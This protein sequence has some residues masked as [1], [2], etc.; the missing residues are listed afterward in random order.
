[1]KQKISETDLIN[2]WMQKIYNTTF[3]EEQN[4]NKKS[5]S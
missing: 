5:N 2:L 3:Q 1:M 4:K